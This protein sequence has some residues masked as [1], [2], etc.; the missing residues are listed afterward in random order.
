MM[1]LIFLFLEYVKSEKKM[2]IYKKDVVKNR[3]ITYKI[4]K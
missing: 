3:K 4:E 2:D 1:F